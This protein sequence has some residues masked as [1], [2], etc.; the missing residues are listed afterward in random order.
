VSV[1]EFD[2]DQIAR[3]RA[4]FDPAEL[5]RQIEQPRNVQRTSATAARPED[6]VNAGG[7]FPAG[8]G[9]VGYGGAIGSA[10]P[11]AS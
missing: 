4:Y 7:P 3:F 11:P 8:E 6:L 1:L 10:S 2:G 5:G 9:A